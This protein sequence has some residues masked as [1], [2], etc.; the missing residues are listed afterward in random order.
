MTLGELIGPQAGLPPSWSRLP[1]TGLTAD[2]RSVEPGF[3]F[4]ALP[5]VK[6]NGTRFIAEAV[7]RG[8]AAILLG[9]GGA[10]ALNGTPVVEDAD[11]RRRL[12]LI[13]AR[14]FGTQPDTEVAVTGTNGKTS[15]A[16]FVRQLWEQQGFKAASLGTVGVVSPSGTETLAHTTPDPVALHAI[17]AKLAHDGVTHLALE[18]SSHGLQQ[19]RVDGVRFKAGAFTNISR[20]HLDYHPSFEDYFAQK[21][22]LFSELLPPGSA[23]VVDV[24]SEAGL[25]V[26][27]EAEARGLR[28]ISVGCA[29][30]TLRLVSATRD[31]F[32]Q[33]LVVA[34]AGKSHAMRLPLVGDF[35]AANALVAVGL[36]L[37]TG[38]SAQKVL[39]L[40]AGLRGARGRL[41]L[42][43]TSPTGAPIFIDYAHTPDALAK[44]LD[45]LRPYAEN[46][47]LVVFGCGGDRDRGKRPEMGAVAQ[48]KADVVFVTDDNPRSEEPSAIRRAILASAPSASE[49]ADRGTAVAR[50][51]AHL[52]PGDVL[53]VAGKGHETGQIVGQTVIPYS[54]HD[55]VAA[56]LLE[57]A[58]N[59]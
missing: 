5:G 43:G 46:R 3:L 34:H 33:R 8:A 59:G 55:A 4:A 45:A 11:P 12:A 44:A 2:S 19:R 21:L 27:A 17:L 39:P 41:D 56:A 54:D 6:T 35:Q 23:A 9:Q 40:L 42:V 51:V 24:D 49:V 1:I 37:A 29:G 48:T 53:L 50:A 7:Q 22:R 57:G 47:L 15:V 31:G 38:G 30:K 58:A 52:R 16:S 32:G 13:A 18:A 14:F 25:R 36:C 10:P 20:D 28:V 26:A